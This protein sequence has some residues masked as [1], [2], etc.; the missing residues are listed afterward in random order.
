MATRTA[1]NGRIRNDFM[2]LPPFDWTYI[3]QW[4]GKIADQEGLS[5]VRLDFVQILTY[6]GGH[7]TAL[8]DRRA[9]SADERQPGLLRVWER[10]YGLLRPERSDGGYRLYSSED[11]ERV[12][13]MVRH[14]EAGVPAGEAARL[15]LEGVGRR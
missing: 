12:R 7:G 8:P 4:L 14:L 5:R 2:M 13:A 6:S 9:R 1:A 3:G 11:E 15:V 10:R